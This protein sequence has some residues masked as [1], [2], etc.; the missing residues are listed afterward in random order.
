MLKHIISIIYIVALLATV[1]C[2]PLSAIFIIV[3]L[4]GA[5]TM[6]W[7]ACCMPAIV[8]LAILPLLLISKLLLDQKGG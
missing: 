5:S 4:C 3:K 6:S 7:L 8:V 2:I 1:V